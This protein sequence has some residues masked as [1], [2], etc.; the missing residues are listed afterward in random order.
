[1]HYTFNNLMDC[2]LCKNLKQFASEVE[3]NSPGKLFNHLAMNKMEDIP[4]LQVNIVSITA[5]MSFN[6]KLDFV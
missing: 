2:I 5:I 4:L 6:T 1:M 3:H